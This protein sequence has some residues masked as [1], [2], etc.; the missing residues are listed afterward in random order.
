MPT[1]W[2]DEGDR[3]ILTTVRTTWRKMRPQH[4]VAGESGPPESGRHRWASSLSRGPRE[5]PSARSRASYFYSVG[6]IALDPLKCIAIAPTW[7]LCIYD[8]DSREIVVG[9]VN[10][11]CQLQRSTEDHDLRPVARKNAWR[12]DSSSDTAIDRWLALISDRRPLRGESWMRDR[13][14]ETTVNRDVTMSIGRWID[15]TNHR[16]TAFHVRNNSWFITDVSRWI[17]HLCAV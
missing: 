17:L 3:T 9:L 7:A 1:A 13:S 14:W 10:K 16:K 5:R 11:K 15:V 6:T 12:R 8:R 4:V 2:E